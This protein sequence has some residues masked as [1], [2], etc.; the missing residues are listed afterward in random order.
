MKVPSSASVRVSTAWA[1]MLSPAVVLICPAL[2][3]LNF[4]VPIAMI[5]MHRQAVAFKGLMVCELCLFGPLV[6]LT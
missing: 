1:A 6:L 2:T 5:F 3:P 4:S